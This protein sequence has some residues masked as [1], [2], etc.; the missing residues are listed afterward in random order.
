MCGGYTSIED[1]QICQTPLYCC[2]PESRIADV[3]GTCI[4]VADLG[5]EGDP[6]GVIS[7]VCCGEDLMCKYADTAEVEEDGTCVP[8]VAQQ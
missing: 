8:I 4:D 7:G 1:A 6:C 3:S 2:A 5:A